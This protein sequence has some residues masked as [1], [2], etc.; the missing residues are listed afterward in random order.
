MVSMNS[1]VR[2]VDIKYLFLKY[3]FDFAIMLS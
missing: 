3:Y 1:D 2:Y